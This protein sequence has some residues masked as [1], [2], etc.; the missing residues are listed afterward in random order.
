[1][2]KDPALLW[3]WGDWLGG[4][5]TFT[6]LQKGA[7]MD[8][9]AAQFNND[10]LTMSEIQVILGADFDTCWPVLNRKFKEDNGKFFNERLRNEKIKRMNYTASR[11][12]NLDSI[13]KK[14]VHMAPHMSTHMDAHMENENTMYCKYIEG[15]NAILGKKYRGSV[16][17]KKSFLARIKDGRTLEDIL[18]AVKNASLDEY[19]IEKKFKYLTVE[20][21]TR[22]D[23]ID[24]F[25]NRTV[26]PQGRIPTFPDENEYSGGKQDPWYIKH[27]KEYNDYQANL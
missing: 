14:E 3:Y 15:V 6:R 19:H 27:L 4:T 16:G 7:Y 17:V 1:M 9:L 20:F 23:K 2:A 25:L 13:P 11:R 26:E 18:K 22:A 21:F 10:S 24:M 5:S 12:N 8:L